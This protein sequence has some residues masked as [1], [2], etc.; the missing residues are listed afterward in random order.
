MQFPKKI[1][2]YIQG[3]EGDKLV[4]ANADGSLPSVSDAASGT[5]IGV[6][7]LVSVSKLKITSELAS[8]NRKVGSR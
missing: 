7:E 3:P 1:F 6:Y 4:V 5:P 8:V 2:G